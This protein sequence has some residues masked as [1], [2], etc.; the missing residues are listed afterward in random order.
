MR[1]RERSSRRAEKPVLTEAQMM[2]KAEDEARYYISR[3]EEPARRILEFIAPQIQ[4]RAY[5]SLLSDDSG[6]RIHTLVLGQAIQDLYGTDKRLG[7]VFVK[8]G[9]LLRHDDPFPGRSYPPSYVRQNGVLRAALASDELTWEPY[10]SDEERSLEEDQGEYVLNRSTTHAEEVREYLT[11]MRPRLGRRTLIVTEEINS[12]SSI[13]ILNE[14]LRDVGVRA[15]AASFGTTWDEDSS[16]ELNPY[17]TNKGTVIYLGYPYRTG[18]TLRPEH[19]GIWDDRRS[20]FGH[21][22]ARRA[23]TL[24]ERFQVVAARRAA[25]DLGH[26]LA[27]WC[28]VEGM[29]F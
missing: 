8:G 29:V 14:L 21:P 25:K 2:Q 22:V 17:I 7:I 27:D 12:G 10:P 19:L 13:D 5:D 15:E 1:F 16:E 20:G 28:R 26:R 18:P 9:S 4:E 6:G 23:S 11:R 3:F 24:E